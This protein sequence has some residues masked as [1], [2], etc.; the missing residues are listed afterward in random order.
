MKGWIRISEG[1]VETGAPGPIPGMPGRSRGTPAG[2]VIAQVAGA[3]LKKNPGLG[4]FIGE[5]GP[6]AHEA[7]EGC[8]DDES[9]KVKPDHEKEGMYEGDR[10]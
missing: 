8:G 9:L 7:E 4:L 5:R 1:G 2:S 6:H 10:R 3:F